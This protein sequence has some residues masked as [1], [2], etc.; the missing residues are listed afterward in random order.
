MAGVC[1]SCAAATVPGFVQCRTCLD[2]LAERRVGRRADG[3]CRDCP[4]WAVPDRVR[5]AI[6]ASKD[7]LRRV[8]KM[9]SLLPQGLRK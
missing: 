4:E 9:S 8:D 5:C 2:S 1:R 3:L 7:R 6:C